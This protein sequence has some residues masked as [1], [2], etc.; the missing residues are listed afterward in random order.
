MIYDSKATPRRRARLDN[1]K[2]RLDIGALKI[3][4][5]PFPNPGGLAHRIV[6][7]RFERILEAVA[8]PVQLG[9]GI[10]DLA[11][12]GGWLEKGVT[13]V[14]IGTAAVKNPGFLH[15]ACSA[16]P[17]HILV[18]LDA[19]D[20]KVATTDGPFAETREQ[21][22]GYYLIDVPD[23][24]AA[25]AIAKKL[26]VLPSQHTMEMMAKAAVAVYEG[27]VENWQRQR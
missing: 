17:G 25:I 19:R 15:D 1:S 23:L 14:I 9:G 16:F 18:G 4:D 24:D 8:M 5:D 21:L 26:P 6:T 7:G 13:R 27:A 2:R 22:G 20:G 11:T 3:H 10:R 12:V